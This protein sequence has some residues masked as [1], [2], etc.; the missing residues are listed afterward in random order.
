MGNAKPIVVL[1]HNQEEW[2]KA[3]EIFASLGVV[4]WWDNPTPKT[5]SCGSKGITI[6]QGKLRSDWATNFSI[7]THVYTTTDVTNLNA[8]LIKRL[9]KNL[10]K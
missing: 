4:H 5:Y 9:S 1:V 3:I 2:D 7:N 6:Y 10:T 8:E